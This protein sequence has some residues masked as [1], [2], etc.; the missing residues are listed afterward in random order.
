M[1]I[2]QFEHNLDNK[3]RLS[4]PAKW[5][6][7]F[8]E[9]VIVTSGLDKS[10]FVFSESEWQNIA[11]SISQNGFL[12]IDSRNFS[13]LIL[14][15]AFDL[16][17]DSHGRVLLP[18]HLIK[19]AGLKTDIVLAGNYNRAEIWDK[20]EFTKLMNG[21]NKNADDIAARMSKII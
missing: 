7:I 16:S 17:I 1:L 6:S 10:L 4:I 3:K 18:D 13:R 12:D 9:K 5:R 11:G 15:N 20:E 8:G 19:Y 2:G 14:S 21:V